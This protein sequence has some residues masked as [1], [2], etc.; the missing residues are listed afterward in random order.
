MSA[1]AKTESATWVI[2][3]PGSGAVISYTANSVKEIGNSLMLYDADG[4][5]VAEITISVGFRKLI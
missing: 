3:K 2:G 1:M 4:K 5:N